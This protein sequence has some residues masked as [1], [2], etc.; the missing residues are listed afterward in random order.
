MNVKRTL[1]A[2]L[3]A[4][5]LSLLLASCGESSP[6]KGNDT[7]APAVQDTSIPVETAPPTE[8][9]LRAMVDDEL[10][11]K[12]F[13]GK[14]FRIITLDNT[15]VNYIVEDLTGEA[16]NDAI[17][18]RNETVESRFDVTLD[19][20]SY[21]DRHACRAA[22]QQ[23]FRA[24]DADAFDLVAYH[25][26]DNGANAMTGMY[27]N[28]YDVPY[29]N[30]DKPWWAD[31]NKEDLTVNGKCFVAMGDI[32]LNTV[33]GVWA[34][35]FNKEMATDLGADNLYEVVRNGEWTI[36]YVKELA[37]RAY[38]DANGDGVQNSGDTYG[39]ASYKGSAMNTYLWAFDNPIIKNDKDGVPQ[40]VMDTEKLPD[41]VV[42]IV[43]MYSSGEGIFSHYGGSST[44]THEEM[45]A[46]GEV[47]MIPTTFGG[48]VKLAGTADFDI[49]VLPYPKW[50][51]EQKEYL[52]MVDGGADTVGVTLLETGEELEFIGLI[53]EA[54]C[55]ESYK[56]VYPVYY[57]IMLKNRYADQPD[58][59][60]MIQLV[61]DGR[62]YDLGYVYDNWM[63]A[64]FWMQTFAQSNNTNV[65]SYMKKAWPAAQKYYDK[66]LDLFQ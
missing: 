24:G 56:Q 19:V 47:L 25:M 28:L 11:E 4:L 17:H 12:T 40:Y 8:A 36:D 49:G 63:A 34:H 16:K 13:G 58:D 35:L 59:A 50:D 29:I 44:S 46:N 54:L 10:P 45:F 18:G 51:T 52:T 6:E 9:E 30:F 20:V 1:A 48:L 43:E 2:L 53:T 62:V 57:D 65:A 21:V 15:K 66:V 37:A 7:S 5:Q 41:I 33:S 61:M 14:V 26:A 32:S 27:H 38:K 64:G 31:S 22:I 60:E 42:T 55:A 23:S 3:A 39:L